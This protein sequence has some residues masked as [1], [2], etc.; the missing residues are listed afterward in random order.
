MT[1]PADLQH[2]TA[3]LPNDAE[4]GW[5]LNT[6]PRGFVLSVRARRRAVLHRATCRDVDRDRKRGALTA[7]GSRQI[8][9]SDPGALREWVR[10]HEPASGPVLDRC[11]K[12]SP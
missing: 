1:D 4:Y 6:H 10:M 8:C 3:E 11:P 2:A 12:C 9:A 7:K 5:W